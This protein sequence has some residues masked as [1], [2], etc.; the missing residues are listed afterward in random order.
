MGTSFKNIVNNEFDFGEQRYADME[1]NDPTP[2]F[3]D[4]ILGRKT[5]Y[6]ALQY[7]SV[8]SQNRTYYQ[9]GKD[10]KHFQ[11][12]GRAFA[13]QKQHVQAMNEGTRQQPP[14]SQRGRYEPLPIPL[15]QVLE[16]NVGVAFGE[17]EA[18]PNYQQKFIP[19]KTPME[20]LTRNFLTQSIDKMS[21][22]RD[23]VDRD[24]VIQMLQGLG[25]FESGDGQKP[26]PTLIEKVNRELPPERQL[27]VV[28]ETLSNIQKSR[29]NQPVP[30]LDDTVKRIRE[31][32]QNQQLPTPNQQRPF[33]QEVSSRE[34]SQNQASPQPQNLRPSQ[35]PIHRGPPTTGIHPRSGSRIVT[36]DGR[37]IPTQSLT[38]SERQQ[39]R[40]QS[41]PRKPAFQGAGEGVA[42]DIIPATSQTQESEAGARVSTT[43]SSTTGRVPT[44]EIQRFNEAGSSSK[45]INLPNQD[46]VAIADFLG[47]RSKNLDSGEP[48][49]N[50]TLVGKIRKESS[51]L[52]L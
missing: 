48:L 1:Y 20:D 37:V 35:Q 38:K 4:P 32:N 28:S 21:T 30:V 18:I 24:K 51:R 6:D 25:L 9:K 14:V 11:Y 33:I 16:P 50:S 41:L 5:R 15:R 19:N 26:L 39:L 13:P 36:K 49:A 43:S 34:L 47:I 7:G 22:D 44:K 40:E 42:Q 23:R 31:H 3:H 2:S 46:I 8:Q 29:P 27:P 52:Q 12:T 45:Q 10:P 17:P